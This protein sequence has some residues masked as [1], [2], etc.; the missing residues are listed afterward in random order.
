MMG[1]TGSG[2]SVRTSSSS[3][4]SK[5]STQSVNRSGPGSTGGYKTPQGQS[6]ANKANAYTST[7]GKNAGMSL[8]PKV[9]QGAGSTLVSGGPGAPSVLVSP[10]YE[11]YYTDRYGNL[12]PVGNVLE[13]YLQDNPVAMTGIKTLSGAGPVDY[14]R[15]ARSTEFREIP[16]D[17]I[18]IP[19]YGYMDPRFSF[20]S[21]GGVGSWD[22]KVVV[23]SVKNKSNDYKLGGFS[24]P[25]MSNTGLG[26]G[27]AMERG[28]FQTLAHEL[29]HVGQFSH[30]LSED[31]PPGSYL[32]RTGELNA[33][34]AY[35]PSSLS[36]SNYGGIETMNRELDSLYAQSKRAK[37]PQYKVTSDVATAGNLGGV[38]NYS[39]SLASG[40]SANAAKS[41]VNESQRLNEAGLN[42]IADRYTRQTQKLQGANN[43]SY[44]NSNMADYAQLDHR[45]REA[46]EA[47]LL[48]NNSATNA[49]QSRFGSASSKSSGSRTPSAPKGK[50]K[51][52]APSKGSSK[53]SSP[54]KSGSKSS[55]GRSR[56]K[57]EK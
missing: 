14:Y 45:I 22:P 56:N 21:S 26:Y 41:M 31:G 42:T 28:H 9:M 17:E 35:D 23:D 39:G 25:I 20:N 6:Q 52:P 43:P 11:S 30:L 49:I 38:S 36:M 4:S 1:G 24:R 10:G 7:Y 51:A 8:T 54:S 29:Q 34:R 44:A 40:L 15:A 55:R 19:A 3:G 53:P 27:S 16:I 37:D 46:E 2:G 47:Q 48:R 12:T 50:T 57:N 18:G 32:T 5:N 33:R 13:N